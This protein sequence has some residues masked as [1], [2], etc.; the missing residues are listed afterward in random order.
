VAVTK[1]LALQSIMN[2]SS[3]LTADSRVLLVIAHP[4]DEAM[5]FSPFLWHCR[6]NSIPVAILCL[7]SGNYCGV[8]HV[9]EQ[10]LYASAQVFGVPVQMTCVIDHKDLQD[11]M[12]NVWPPTVIAEIIVNHV[13]KLARASFDV[14]ALCCFDEYG[15]SGHPN[16]IAS[17]EGTLL[18]LKR[19]RDRKVD[20][21]VNVVGEDEPS[22][23]Q[24][25]ARNNEI[26]AL[27]LCSTSLFRK[28]L[29]I[30][31]VF[32]SLFLFRVTILLQSLE[33]S[34]RKQSD[35]G[36]TD[37]QKESVVGTIVGRRKHC[38]YVNY[39]DVIGTVK[40]MFCHRSQLVWFRYFSIV[41]SR[42]T[43]VNE[44]EIV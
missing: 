5:F 22:A 2:P 36:F 20:G 43:Y 10:E 1:R 32:V 23:A 30:W 44:F 41:L 18:A 4:D 8:G 12:N 40:A 19:L 42:F 25:A 33:I 15:V 21:R 28:Y 3:L 38:I 24:G 17:C 39:S 14:T 37:S 29:G 11:G 16:H 27:K 13:S 9:R 7:S 35:S 31:D 6:R 34:K 26:G